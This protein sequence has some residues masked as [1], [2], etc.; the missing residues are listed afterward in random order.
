ML[1]GNDFDFPPDTTVKVMY[2][3]KSQN[4]S[5][6]TTG[7]T[8]LK[9]VTTESMARNQ[10]AA[11]NPNMEVR[12]LGIEYQKSLYFQVKYQY[13]NN[14]NGVWITGTTSLK[15]SLTESMAIN[16]LLNKYPN[17]DVKVLSIV[18]K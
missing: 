15:N 4:G 13:R 3:L 5:I 14:G 12:I 2:Q 6:W 8:T 7:N 18:K 16:Q 1:L 9:N 10:I 17:C 11:K